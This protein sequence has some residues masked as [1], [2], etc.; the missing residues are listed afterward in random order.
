M[1]PAQQK[2][3]LET[4]LPTFYVEDLTVT[5]LY[6]ETEEFKK[7]I[8]YGFDSLAQLSAQNRKDFQKILAHPDKYQVVCFFEPV[9]SR[10]IFIGRTEEI[11]QDLPAFGP[12]F[13]SQ[14]W[15]SYMDNLLTETNYALSTLNRY[16][17]PSEEA[18]RAMKDGELSVLKKNLSAFIANAKLINESLYTSEAHLQY[19]A[20]GPK[21]LKRR[22]EP[23]GAF[24]VGLLDA[25]FD[26]NSE[27]LRNLPKQFKKFSKTFK[28]FFLQ[29][30]EISKLV[31]KEHQNRKPSFLKRKRKMLLAYPIPAILSVVLAFLGL[32][33]TSLLAGLPFLISAFLLHVAFAAQYLRL[34]KSFLSVGRYP[35]PAFNRVQLFVLALTQTVYKFAVTPNILAP[36]EISVSRAPGRIERTQKNEAKTS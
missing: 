30:E 27:N 34:R 5:D 25:I 26:V 32:Q 16:P 18:I 21:E 36:M 33:S 10:L 15:S 24:K 7:R 28:D 8:I 2:E 14:T 1:P 23:T 29:V 6:G 19:L 31:E 20:S 3:I 11:E 12:L 35:S 4:M 17:F 22:L 9:K 13:L